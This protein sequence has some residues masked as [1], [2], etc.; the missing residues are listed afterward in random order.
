MSADDIADI[1]NRNSNALMNLQHK[2]LEERL[3]REKAGKPYEIMVT[4]NPN[5][6]I[7]IETYATVDLYE[8][9]RRMIFGH[10]WFTD[11][12]QHEPFKVWSCNP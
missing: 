8:G 4:F 7:Q 11:S 10:Q 9:H 12:G 5:L 3:V 2:I 6:Q 1:M